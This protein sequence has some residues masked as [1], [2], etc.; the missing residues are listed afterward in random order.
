MFKAKMD[1]TEETCLRLGEVQN[2]CFG[3]LRD[4]I[5][6]LLAAVPLLTGCIVGID[7]IFGVLLIVLA[8]MFYYKTAF[9]YRRDAHKAYSKTPERFRH[10]EYESGEDEI[11]I[12]SGG[13]EKKIS[14]KALYALRTDSDYGYLFING[15][16]AYMFLWTALSPKEQDDFKEFIARKTG[17]NWETV[18]IRPSFLDFLGRQYE[19]G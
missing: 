17:K 14:Y 10:V 19:V 5:R 16:Q 12:E 7:N 3:K 9:M 18:K 6:I 11:C 15:Q 4:R 2:R 8:C 13:A 1:H